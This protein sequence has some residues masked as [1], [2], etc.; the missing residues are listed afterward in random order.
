MIASMSTPISKRS[1][2]EFL[3]NH[4]QLFSLIIVLISSVVS[5]VISPIFEPL[6]KSTQAI[7]LVVVIG[8]LAGVTSFYFQLPSWWVRINSVF[9]LTVLIFL[10]LKIPSWAYLIALIGLASIYW[11]TLV[12]RVPYYPSNQMVWEEI[13]KLLPTTSPIKVLEIGSGLGG[14]TRF[15]SKRHLNATFIGLETAPVPW[16]MS[17][18]LAI[19][20]SA[21][22]TFFRKNY[23]QEDF[24]QYDLIFAFLSPA[25]MPNL[26]AKA[27]KEMLPNTQII[28]YM[29]TWPNEAQ[30]HIQPIVLNN[31]EYLY[32]Y[33]K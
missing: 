1:S 3:L 28:S 13:E 16:L 2:K 31:Q 14:F 7:C 9:A 32:V 12:T 17:K 24:S 23:A 33:K 19:F 8:L 18:L 30:A 11:T 10:S 4:P 20:E 26:Y 6:S 15:L 5:F 21:P 25:A 27:K 29:F 22:G